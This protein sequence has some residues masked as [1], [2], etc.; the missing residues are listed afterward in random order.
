MRTGPG[1]VSDFCS[2]IY[3]KKNMTLVGSIPKQ[4]DQQ[5]KR[6]GS[7][8]W[9]WKCT[10]IST[11]KH[12]GRI[13][14]SKQGRTN[15]PESRWCPPWWAGVCFSAGCT[16]TSPSPECRSHTGSRGP[17]LFAPADTQHP[18]PMS[19]GGSTA[20]VFLLLSYWNP[21]LRLN[22]SINK[23][24]SPLLPHMMMSWWRGRPPSTHL[25]GVNPGL[26]AAYALHRGDCGSVEL[27]ERQQ[28]GV[29][30]VM[31]DGTVKAN[32]ADGSDTCRSGLLSLLFVLPLVPNSATSLQESLYH[33]SQRG[34]AL[35]FL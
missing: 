2:H 32:C 10:V 6:I 26:G 22:K 29:G 9:H 14:R 5:E 19:R 23:W 27:T 13:N 34:Y 8:S 33:L 12:N 21:I 25:H 20:V 7:E 16:W 1:C 15:Q 11:S 24:S 18:Q 30:R 28:A 4:L 3:F 17:S 35:Y 31:S